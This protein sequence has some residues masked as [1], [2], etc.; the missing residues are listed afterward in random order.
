MP[1]EDYR[2]PDQVLRG[3]DQPPLTEQQAGDYPLRREPRAL[4]F[5]GKKRPWL[6]SLLFAATAASCFFVGISWSA[7]YVYADLLGREAN[8]SLGLEILRNPKVLKLSLI[9]AAALIA[10]LLAHEMGHYL[11]CRYYGIDATLPYFIPAPTLIGTMGAFI[12]IR[13]PITKKHQLFDVGIA[14]PLAGF[15]LAVPA[16]VYGLS[17]S[18]AIPPLPSEGSIV[19]GEPL[20]FKLL[21]GL[22]FKG[23]PE[24]YDLILH[25][26]AFAGWVGILVTALNLFPV[27]QLDGGHI[28]YA[29]FGQRSRAFGRPILLAFLMMGAVFW[30]GWFI[31]ALLIG[32]IGLKHPRLFDEDIP[33]SSGRRVLAFAVIIIFIFSFIPDPVKGFRLL[34][35]LK[36]GLF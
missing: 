18:K 24:N 14:G 11:T 10:I 8:L 4:S 23:L 32:I 19:F 5:F 17:L 26:V 9:Y 33:I 2:E 15:I 29:L 30:V 25:P 31:W 3:S 13:S 16:T 22:M 21:S 28:V 20:L 6:N 34:D 1:I 35:L 7:N 36:D 27:G 12:K